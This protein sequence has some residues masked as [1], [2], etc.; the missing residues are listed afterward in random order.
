MK[1]FFSKLFGRRRK[2]KHIWDTTPGGPYELT[3]TDQQLTCTHPSRP[4]ES[5]QWDQVQEITLVTTSD[6]PF[7]PDVWYVFT[8]DG[9]GCSVPSEAKGFDGL[10][11][12]FKCRF[13][14]IDYEAIT[15]AGTSDEKKVIWRK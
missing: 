8:G 15:A 3:I 14:T 9:A 10:W 2:E 12:V 4:A 5:I 11:E 6:G 13:P 7:L 1:N